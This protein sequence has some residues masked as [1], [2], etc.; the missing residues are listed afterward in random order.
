MADKVGKENSVGRVKYVI[1]VTIPLKLK[2]HN[3]GI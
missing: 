3:A 1:N 2:Y